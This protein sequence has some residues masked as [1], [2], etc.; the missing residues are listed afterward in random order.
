MLSRLASDCARLEAHRTRAAQ[1]PRVV[2]IAPLVVAQEASGTRDRVLRSFRLGVPGETSIIAGIELIIRIDECALVIPKVG[3]RRAKR[4]R[5]ALIAHQKRRG[6]R[7]KVEKLGRQIANAMQSAFDSGA[8]E[9]GQRCRRKNVCNTRWN[10]IQKCAWQTPDS[11]SRIEPECSTMRT[12]SE[13]AFNQSGT[14]E[15]RETT[16]IMFLYPH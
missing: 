9:G 13:D 7:A 12:R 5:T 11:L 1:K 8:R 6:V 14:C 10:R 2:V 15:G 16:S 3:Q 4:M